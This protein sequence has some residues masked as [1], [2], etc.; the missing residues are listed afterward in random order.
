MDEGIGEEALGGA[1][2]DAG[3][4]GEQGRVEL[5]DEGRGLEE[6]G[7]VLGVALQE[8]ADHPV[9]LALEILFDEQATR[10]LGG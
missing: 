3:H 6:V 10:V 8:T 4:G 7:L 1:D 5:G 2:P 9:D